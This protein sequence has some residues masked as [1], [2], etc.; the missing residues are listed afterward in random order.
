M[1]ETTYKCDVQ[2]CDW[3][4]TWDIFT[5]K[6][7]RG[8]ADR[9][10]SEKIRPFDRPNIEKMDLCREHYILWCKT[11]YELFYGEVKDDEVVEK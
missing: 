10:N 6:T 5:V 8:Y 4:S 3:K 2:G 7:C 1:K 9:I 11:T